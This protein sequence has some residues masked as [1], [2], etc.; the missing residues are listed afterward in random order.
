MIGII[1]GYGDI[2]H[3]VVEALLSQGNETLLIGAR[4]QKDMFYNYKSVKY[5]Y[6]DLGDE[7]S[8]EDFAKKMYSNYKLF[9]IERKYDGKIVM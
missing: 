1:G 5:Q 8:L 7:S 6:V 9:G 3:H 2:G 4:K